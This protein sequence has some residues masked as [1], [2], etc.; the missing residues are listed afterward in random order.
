VSEAQLNNGIEAQCRARGLRL[1]GQRRLIAQLIT[2]ATDHPDI[3]ELHR[4]ARVSDPRIAL[5]TVYRTLNK[6]EGAGIVVSHNFRG[7]P[8]R[9]ELAS[10]SCHDHLIDV[11]T[12]AVLDF[13]DRR[14][15]RAI[16]KIARA[17]GFEVVDHR[18]EV[19]VIPS[20][21]L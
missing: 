5:S 10:K 9:Y 18:L 20:R 1:T 11:Q 2:E 6:L 14:V 3:L 8:S 21:A 13:Q 19:H 17:L 7:G 15:D 12:G 4:R 16:E